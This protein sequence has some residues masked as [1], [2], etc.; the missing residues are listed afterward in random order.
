MQTVMKC[1]VMIV[2]IDK[3]E[4]C[5]Y[6]QIAISTANSFNRF[7]CDVKAFMTRRDAM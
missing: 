6:K 7:A 2:V 4:Y 3:M 1:K 5:V